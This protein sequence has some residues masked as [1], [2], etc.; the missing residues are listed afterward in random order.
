MFFLA[1]A[2][3]TDRFLLS[4]QRVFLG[5]FARKFPDCEV[6]IAP[7]QYS[8]PLDLPFQ[9][10]GLGAKR[11]DGVLGECELPFADEFEG[12]EILSLSLGTGTFCEVAMVH[13]STKTLLIVDSVVQCP[14]EPP[15][16]C[17][18]DPSP[19]LARAKAD[20]R[21]PDREPT[22][23]V[24]REGWAKTALFGLF[25]QP[26]SVEYKPSP[27]AVVDIDKGFTWTERWKSSFARISNKV[28]VAPILQQVVLNKRPS[29]ALEWVDRVA[30]MGFNKVVPAHLQ[31][32]IQLSPAQ[33]KA[34]FAF[35][36]ELEAERQAAKKGGAVD[37]ERDQGRRRPAF[38]LPEL[39]L[40]D[41]LQQLQGGAGGGNGDFEA[42]DMQFLKDL[43]EITVKSGF[44]KLEE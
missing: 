41:F 8:V 36:R 26:V 37:E 2:R 14:A 3:F 4:S 5:P 40:P 6:Y 29:A 10:L 7:G 1:A 28:F 32:P 25:F 42:D 35:L 30:A 33:F 12:P 24:L 20:G 27:A 34:K 39:R 43:D 22:P 38:E 44:V 9:W 16:V 15:E 18:V 21:E 19:L 11:V 31:A 17:R 13:K 23:A